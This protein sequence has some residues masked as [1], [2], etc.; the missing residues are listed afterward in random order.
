MEKL[1]AVLNSE[2]KKSATGFFSQ[3]YFL[4]LSLLGFKPKPHTLFTSPQDSNTLI[5]KKY[6]NIYVPCSQAEAKK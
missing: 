5:E 6:S 2:V 1:L 3:S 4:F